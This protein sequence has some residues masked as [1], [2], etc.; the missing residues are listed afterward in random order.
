MSVLIKEVDKELYAK[1]KSKA[2]LKGLRINEAFTEAMIKWLAEEQEKGEKD[3]MRQQN[4][5]TYR[6][7]LPNLIKEYENKWIVISEGL[8][9]GIFENRD[10]AIKAVKLNKLENKHNIVSPIL[11]EGRRTEFGFRRKES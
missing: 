9:I 3:L 5:A 2:A 11:K 6:R 7:T 1:F 10:E 8:I 4:N